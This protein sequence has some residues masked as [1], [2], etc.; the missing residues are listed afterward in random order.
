MRLEAFYNKE[1]RGQIGGPLKRAGELGIIC[2][3]IA[4][5]FCYPHNRDM[6]YGTKVDHTQ[7]EFKQQKNFQGTAI[8]LE[9]TLDFEGI[10]SYKSS[11]AVINNLYMEKKNYKDAFK[12]SETDIEF[13]YHACM[14]I[15][16]SIAELAMEQGTWIFS[17]RSDDRSVGNE[18]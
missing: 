14:M 1:L 11:V 4:D 3:F 6:F 13:A 12:G 10:K 5:Y 15:A 7:Y 18:C 17:K 9:E 2:Q 8:E 16:K